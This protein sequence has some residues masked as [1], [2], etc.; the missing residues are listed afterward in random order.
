MKSFESDLKKSLKNNNNSIQKLCLFVLAFFSFNLFLSGSLSGYS[1]IIPAKKNDAIVRIATYNIRSGDSNGDG[2]YQSESSKK[3]IIEAVKHINADILVL[4]EVMLTKSE[5]RAFLSVLGYT[6]FTAVV[7]AK[8]GVQA[9]SAGACCD[10]V[11]SQAKNYIICS[12]IPI[13]K[14]NISKKQI[15][16]YK[17]LPAFAKIEVDFSSYDK[18]YGKKNLIMYGV[19]FDKLSQKKRLSQAND[20]VNLLQK[21]DNQGKNILFAAGFNEERGRAINYLGAHGFINSFDMMGTT[22]MRPLLSSAQNIVD[23]IYVYRESWN[24]VCDGSYLFSSQLNNHLSI[25]VDFD[26]S[27]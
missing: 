9:T 19:L 16:A 15:Y 18:N 8:A 12:K 11:D 26:L 5:V 14:T 21:E 22:M 24:L 7:S 20:L 17:H 2:D 6:Y 4:Q 25:I 13:I 27:K 23:G 1:T 10:V 3:E